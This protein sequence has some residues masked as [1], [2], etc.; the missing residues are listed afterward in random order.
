MDA[1]RY[2]WILR[3]AVFG[4]RLEGRESRLNESWKWASHGRWLTPGNTK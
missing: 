3:R 1:S 4:K 2:V